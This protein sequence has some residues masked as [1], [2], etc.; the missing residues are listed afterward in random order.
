MYTQRV[1]SL[2]VIQHGRSMFVRI[3]QATRG[4]SPQ[5]RRP[6]LATAAL[7]ARKETKCLLSMP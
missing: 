4:H 7:L 5:L 3:A 2:E 6:S 1:A